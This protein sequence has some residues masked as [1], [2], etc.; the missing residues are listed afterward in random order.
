MSSP[1]HLLAAL[2]DEGLAV[3]NMEHGRPAMALTDKGREAVE[4]DDRITNKRK[5]TP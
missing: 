4:E 3:V 1:P 5:M 2:I